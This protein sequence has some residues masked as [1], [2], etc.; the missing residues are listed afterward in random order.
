MSNTFKKKVTTNIEVKK[1]SPIAMV[2]A[3]GDMWLIEAPRSVSVQTQVALGSM[4]QDYRE[5][6]NMICMEKGIVG[7]IKHV[8]S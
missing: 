5:Y 1:Y 2:T 8:E 6:V 3:R 7:R 4:T